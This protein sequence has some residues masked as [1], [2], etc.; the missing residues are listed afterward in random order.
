MPD[1]EQKIIATNLTVLRKR[2]NLTQQNVAENLGIKRPTYAKYETNIMPPL[3]ILSKL[4]DM[5]DITLE[6]LT[7]EEIK[8][9]GGANPPAKKSVYQEI[10]S[11]HSKESTDLVFR[12]DEELPENPY[13]KSLKINE[14]D[15]LSENEKR[16][17]RA[18]RNASEQKRLKMLDVAAEEEN[19]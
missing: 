6:Q 11:K 1:I 16:M 19:N 14:F 12:T 2:L 5:F 7:K 4:A 18:Y 15:F 10:L 8:F 3:D 9:T 17:I 13:I